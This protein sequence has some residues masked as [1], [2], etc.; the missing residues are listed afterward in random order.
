HDAPVTGETADQTDDGVDMASGLVNKN[1]RVLFG[2]RKDIEIVPGVAD[3]SFVAKNTFP[4]DAVIRF[5][6]VHM[7]LRGK[8]MAMRFTY[9]DGRK[10]DVLEVPNYNFNWQRVYI[11]KEPL[12]VPK[13]RT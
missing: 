12:R 10:E 9:P 1:V 6:H 2:D 13:G 11:L 8:A 3:Q 5:M 7:H 4:T